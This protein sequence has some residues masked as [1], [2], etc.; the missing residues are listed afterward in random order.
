MFFEAAGW[1]RPFWY[2]ANEELLAEYG[3]RV[4]PRDGRVGVAL[5]V[6][7]H[8]RRAPRDARP[9]RRWSTS[10][11]SRSSTSPARAPSPTSRGSSSARWTCPVGRVVY[12]PLLSENGGI[13]ADLTIIRL[14][15]D[16][17]RVVT[18]GGMG[19][20]DKKWFTDHLP[21]DGSAQLHDQTSALY[22]LGSVGPAGPRRPARRRPRDDV[23]NAGFPF[24]TVETIEIGGG[25]GAGVADLV[26][27]RARLGDLRPDGAGPPAVGHALGGRRAV[28]RRRRRDRRVRARPAGSRRATAPTATSSSSNTTS[29]RPAWPDRRSRRPTSSARR[30]TS[31]QRSAPPAA[32]LCTLTVDDP[33]S[34]T[35]VERYMMGKEPILTP[36][37]PAAG[38]CEGPPVVRDER[39]LGAVGR[40]APADVVPAAGAGRRRDDQLAVE[41]FGERYPVTVAVAG[42]TPL[43]DPTNE[44][45]RS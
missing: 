40:Q 30:R 8:Q 7:D 45:I 41:Y 17:F 10:P 18:G 42:S 13:V 37:R 39:R 14:A 27:R 34:S 5:V 32:I 33:T 31:R 20:R 6:A 12:T 36:R 2:G 16:T 26:R 44:R 15:H 24:G 23:S 19:M 43:F 38:R 28:R 35:G 1:E 3:D 4:M 22:T 9:R 29:S 11:R 21:A 25:P